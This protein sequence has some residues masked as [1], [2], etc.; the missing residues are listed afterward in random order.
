MRWGKTK[1]EKKEKEKKESYVIEYRVNEQMKK[2]I[3]IKINS[4]NTNN[5][6]IY[7]TSDL[8]KSVY[9]NWYLLFKWFLSISPIPPLFLFRSLFLFSSYSFIYYFFFLFILN[10]ISHSL[11]LSLFLTYYYF[12][13]FSLSLVCKRVWFCLPWPCRTGI[14]VGSRCLWGGR[15]EKTRPVLQSSSPSDAALVG[16]RTIGDLRRKRKGKINK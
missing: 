15:A 10:F 7:W 1:R 8:I 2:R 13:S 4:V 5:I 11:I 3:K 9:Y 12:L 6:F 14:C 16:L